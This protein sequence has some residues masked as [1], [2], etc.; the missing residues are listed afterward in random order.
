MQV[1]AL[2]VVVQAGLP[3]VDVADAGAQLVGQ[4]GDRFGYQSASGDL[5]GDGDLDLVVTAP[6]PDANGNAVYVFFGGVALDGNTTLDVTMADVAIVGDPGDETGWS[7]T[8]GDVI[9]DASLDLVIGSPSA[10]S[11]KGSVGVFEGPLTSGSYATG[12]AS[13]AVTGDVAG[14]YAGWS[15]ATGDFDGDGQGELVIG[16]CGVDSSAGA[17]YLL[18]LDQAPSSTTDASAVFQGIGLTGCSMANVGDFNDDGYEDL[19]LGSY[20]TAQVLPRSYSGA[21]T[22]IY[23]RAS[24]DPIYDLLN[25][26]PAT[27]DIAYLHGA[28]TGENFGFDLAPAGDVN[29]DGFDDFLIG[30]PARDCDAQPSCATRVRRG[31][32]YLVLGTPDTAP[33]GGTGR[34]LHG[35]SP[36]EDIADMTWVGAADDD[37]TGIS[38]AG[39]GWSGKLYGR[40]TSPLVIPNSLHYGKVMLLGTGADLAYAMPYDVRPRLKAFPKYICEID[41]ETGLHCWLAGV[42]DPDAPTPRKIVRGLDKMNFGG[43]VFVGAPGSAFGL[44]VLGTGDVDGDGGGDFFFGA[45]NQV[46]FEDPAGDGE[47][48]VFPGR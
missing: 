31:R 3:T 39:A 29:L 25:G 13:T 30:A 4:G 16:A 12:D 28:S 26:D 42:P 45:P 34:G 43:H 36:G 38:V 20:G 27:M 41:P 8:V 32:V 11:G 22:L 46:T 48:F 5:D 14:A 19:A 35:T 44:E 17:A 21:V 47:G 33:G 1:M 7:V 9:G 6:H 15:V 37:L 24:F 2:M 23:G 18:D 10:N 40:T